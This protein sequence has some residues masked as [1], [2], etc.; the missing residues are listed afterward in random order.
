MST[1]HVCIH[2]ERDNG[3]KANINIYCLRLSSNLVGLVLSNFHLPSQRGNVSA[4][5]N[6]RKEF[7]DLMQFS[8]A[9]F[10]ATARRIGLISILLLADCFSF[11]VAVRFIGLFFTLPKST[12]MFGNHCGSSVIISNVSS[13]LVVV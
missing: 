11:S 7:N 3:R 6:V 12:E 13:S 4:T 5:G 9:P 2:N 1:E 8:L 10:F